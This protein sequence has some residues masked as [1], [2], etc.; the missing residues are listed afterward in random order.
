MLIF[1]LEL[2][3]NEVLILPSHSSKIVLHIPAGCANLRITALRS[4][5]VME[6]T[7]I[8]HTV[9]PL[10]SQ[11]AWEQIPWELYRY[12]SVLWKQRRES[13][14]PIGEELRVFRAEDAPEQAMK[15]KSFV[16]H[17]LRKSPLC[18]CSVSTSA[19]IQDGRT[20]EGCWR[21]ES[22]HLPCVAVGGF[23]LGSFLFL[24]VSGVFF[25][26]LQDLVTHISVT[27]QDTVP[28]ACGQEEPLGRDS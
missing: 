28:D 20:G 26:S 24:F 25:Y 18:S 23:F 13:C 10:D 1:G 22:V 11:V 8:G 3:I 2:S 14:L 27:F 9:L 12:Q 16:S 19:T 7:G 15:H 5:N 21:E 6:N 4:L 17:A